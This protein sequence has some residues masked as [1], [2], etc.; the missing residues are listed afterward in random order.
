[1]RTAA[2]VVEYNP[3][4]TGHIYH[5]EKTREISGADFVVVVMSGDFTQRGEPA[6]FDKWTRS[7]IAVCN[8]A[9]LVLELPFVFACNSAGIL[10]DGSLGHLKGLGCVDVLSF[11]SESGD[12]C[13]NWSL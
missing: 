13:I 8:G 7:R 11:G 10:C 4:H 2:V 9:D 6:I 12:I 3:M 5:L 1:M